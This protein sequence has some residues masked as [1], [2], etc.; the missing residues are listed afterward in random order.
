VTAN[1]VSSMDHDVKPLAIFDLDDTLVDYTGAILVSLDMFA[2]ERSLGEEGRAFLRAEHARPGDPRDSWLSI[3]QRF[4]LEE[5]PEDLLDAF[6]ASLPARVKSYDGVTEGL[7]R[8]KSLGWKIALI[9][10]GEEVAQCAKM[11]AE[12]RALFDVAC[13]SETEKIS[14]PD[15][16]IFHAVLQRA[17]ATPETCWMVG[18]SLENDVGGAV[19]A[20]LRAIWVSGDQQLPDDAARPQYVARD[21]FEAFRLLE[22]M[23]P[24]VGDGRTQSSHH[25]PRKQA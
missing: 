6:M 18:D 3:A 12:L 21:V 13:F 1:G 10:N 2:T 24:G 4:N 5:T 8:L 11:P 25:S 16:A 20:G 9:T 22:S 23:S 14:K 19:A 7:A 15:P 17:Q